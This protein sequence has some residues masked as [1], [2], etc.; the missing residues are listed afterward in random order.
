LL[1]ISCVAGRTPT[2]TASYPPPE[3]VRAA[4]LALLDRPKVPLAPEVLA[5]EAVGEGLVQERLRFATEKSADGAREWVPALV[6]RPA[7]EDKRRPAVIVLHGTGG[8]KEGERERSFMV[9]LARRGILGVAIDA[10]YHGERSGGA[11]GAEAYNAAIIR[12]W[13]ARPGEKQE[14]PWFF[15]TCWDIWRTLDYLETR[16]DVDVSR[17][18][19]IGFSMG[20]VE[21]W[22]AGAVDPRVKVAVPAISVQS[23]RWMLENDRWKGRA[24]TI[25]AAHDAAAAD[26]G[27]TKIDREVCRTLWNKVAPGLLDQFDAPSMLRLFAPDRALLILGSDNDPNCPIEGARLAFDAAAKAYGSAAQERL[28]IDIASGAGHHVTG[29]QRERALEWFT[30]WFHA[31]GTGQSGIP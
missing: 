29:R 30:R 20:G 9:E 18:G 26:L 12:A 3:V 2:P 7:P 19:V 11:R 22:L 15:D 31:T 24:H 16:A 13:R 27:K 1:C 14:H 4:F 8:S 21:T 5:L 6:I 25:K 10:R 23:V 17:L 28:A